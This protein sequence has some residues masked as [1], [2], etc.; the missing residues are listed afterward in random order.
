VAI[1]AKRNLLLAVGMVGFVACLVDNPDSPSN[2]PRPPNADKQAGCAINCHGEDTSNAPPKSLDGTVATTAVGVGAHATHMT[3][4]ST[5]HAPI[6]C[7]DC[8]VVPTAVGSPGHIDGDN[9][10][11]VIFSV[12][13]AST[14]NG[15]TCTS[16]CHGAVEKGGSAPNPKWTQ[17][18][19]TQVTCGSCHGVPPPAPH[20]ADTNC[21]SCHPTMENGSMLFR[22]PM[23]HINGVIDL[24][25]NTGGGCSS[26]HGSAASSAP[27]KDL[28]GDTAPT[29][30]GVG[31]HAKHAGTSD[32][33]REIACSSC[34]LVPVTDGD[35]KHRD[36]DN[37][38]E[39]KFD[40]LNPVGTYNRA[41]ASCGTSYCHGNGRGSNGTV[42]WTT[43]GAKTCTSCH[44]TS[45]T[46]MSGRHRKHIADENMTCSECHGAVVDATRKIIDAKLHIN[47]VHEIKMANGTF[48]AA[49]RSCANTGCHGTETW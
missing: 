15:T 25:P 27:P 45:G 31:A 22:N 18:D 2:D 8:H 16:E 9:K 30:Q 48:N 42:A 43:P 24:D 7:A 13:A 10:A 4:A 39:L 3:L 20:P 23:S 33:H 26:C 46:G 6:L 44:A 11:E 34:H 28:S 40:G 29:A 1:F 17:V 5:W 41:T 19:G 38:A 35:P 36:G 32:W 49:T 21:A 37:I 14:W 12:R 47:G